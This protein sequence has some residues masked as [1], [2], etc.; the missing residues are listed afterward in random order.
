MPITVLIEF[1]K[2]V[3]HVQGDIDV[4]RIAPMGLDLA[5]SVPIE[6]LEIRRNSQTITVDE[7]WRTP[8]PTSRPY[9][10]LS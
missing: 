10:V 1:L 2:R 4:H 6:Q 7:D 8:V 5:Y 9:V 3:H